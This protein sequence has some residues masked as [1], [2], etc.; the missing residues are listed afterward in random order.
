MCIKMHAKKIIEVF[1]PGLLLPAVSPVLANAG[2][3][4]QVA[5]G[6]FANIRNLLSSA[7]IRNLL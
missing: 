1:T 4:D 6:R 7:K 5:A 3:D 2:L